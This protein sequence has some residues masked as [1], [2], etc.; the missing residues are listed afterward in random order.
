MAKVVEHVPSKSE[1]LNS[2]PEL[3]STQVDKGW[4]KCKGYLLNPDF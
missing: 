2:N 1:A 4:E 3:Q